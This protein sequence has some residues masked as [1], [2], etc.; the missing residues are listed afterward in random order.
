MK[1]ETCVFHLLFSKKVSSDEII[2]K[3]Y[4]LSILDVY[5]GTSSHLIEDIVNTSKFDKVS[6]DIEIN[7]K[8][9]YAGR[10]LVK[11]VQSLLDSTA[12]L[13]HEGDYSTEE[14]YEASKLFGHSLLWFIDKHKTLPP[15]NTEVILVK[16]YPNTTKNLTSRRN[17][18][19]TI[20]RKLL[21]EDRIF[22]FVSDNILR[23]IS[24]TD[25]ATMDMWKYGWKSIPGAFY[26][27]RGEEENTI[28]KYEVVRFSDNGVE[29]VTD[30]FTN[31]NYE[32]LMK[33]V[34]SEVF[35]VTDDTYAK[36]SIKRNKPY[37]VPAWYKKFGENN[38]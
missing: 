12:E 25:L 27:L 28:Y 15:E 38:G 13:I 29:R 20:G 19:V 9:L 8:Y 4:A 33:E 16:G 36:L 7:D 37:F 24:L 30:T 21:T 32:D 5:H 18:K 6:I 2:T 35:T 34:K 31:S 11:D 17:A 3:N 14:F 1:Y 22:G 26:R 10:H 23:H